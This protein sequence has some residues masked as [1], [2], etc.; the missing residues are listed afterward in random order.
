MNTSIEE[1][2]L[3]AD[4]ARNAY[5]NPSLRFWRIRR[6]FGL[7][8]HFVTSYSPSSEI[9]PEGD[10]AIFLTDF[11]GTPVE[12]LGDDPN[13]TSDHVAALEAAGFTVTS[14]LSGDGR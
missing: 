3:P 4:F 2:E 8:W 6:H 1:I 7:R 9:D 10:L 5:K 12:L 14:T 13:P 11:L